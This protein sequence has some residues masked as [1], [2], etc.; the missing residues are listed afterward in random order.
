[1]EF[2]IHRWTMTTTVGDPNS[3][4]SVPPIKWVLM[5]VVYLLIPAILWVCAG[6]LR[7]WQGWVFTFLIFLSGMGGRILA[8]RR[9]PG[10]MAERTQTPSR[11]DVKPW[12]RILS[13]LMSVSVSFPLVIVAGLDHRFG[14]TQS[15]PLW[16]NILGLVLVGCGYALAVWALVENKFFSGVVRIQTDRG[17]TVCDRGPYRLM[18]HPGYAGNL[19]PLAGIVLALNSLWTIIPAGVALAITVLRTGLED[20]TL[21]TELPGYKEYAD[22]VRYRLFPGIW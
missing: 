12:D 7:W 6:S 20:C 13:P 5:G 8:E 14:W 3:V 2:L 1:M 15:F 4:K 19:L 17:H 16:L 10:L 22:R 11:K 18:R 21:Q 9:H